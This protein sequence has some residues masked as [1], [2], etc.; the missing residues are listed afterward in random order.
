MKGHYVNIVRINSVSPEEQERRLN[1]WSNLWRAG[2]VDLD[3]ALRKGG[4]SNP[5]EVRSKILEEQFI[6]SPGIQEQLHAA[7]A[8]RIPTIQNILEA[9][10]QQGSP[11]LPTPEETAQ[12]IL[13]TQGAQQLPNA[14]NF[15]QGNQAG[16]RPQAPGTGIP[17]TTRPVIPGSVD[18][19]R[20]TAAAIAGP[21][22]GNVRVPG[23]DISP[24][25]R[26]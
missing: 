20:Q 18:E 3:T 24:G 15:Q 2:Y 12:N 6:N 8:A 9:A 1:L 10:Q 19:M 14:G 7:A 21:R 23:A 26:G 25:A 11:Q 17:A 16:T 5:L 13:N 4:V 22:S